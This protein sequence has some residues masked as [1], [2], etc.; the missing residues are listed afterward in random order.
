VKTTGQ[1]ASSELKEEPAADLDAYREKAMTNPDAV[2][3]PDADALRRQM[4]KLLEAAIAKLP[5]SF[6]VVFMLREVEG[7][8]VEETAEALQITRETLKTRLARA[9][10]ELQQELDS[11]L[12]NALQDTFTFA[13]SDC[14]ALTERVLATFIANGRS[15]SS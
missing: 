4:T 8:S 1:K 5:E 10:C 7:L 11:K 9:R 3:S 15:Q 6:R 13:G 14:D 12:R 2:H